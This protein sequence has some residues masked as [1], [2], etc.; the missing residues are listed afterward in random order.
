MTGVVA[1]RYTLDPSLRPHIRH[2][3]GLGEQ[4]RYYAMGRYGRMFSGHVSSVLSGHE[5]TG[6]ARGHFHACFLPTDEDADGLIDHLT[7]YARDG[8]EPRDL[9]ALHSLTFLSWGSDAIRL[10]LIGMYTRP[11]SEA[12]PSF[13]P[14]TRWRSVTPMVLFRHPKKYRRGDPKLNE[15]GRQIDGPEDQLYREWGY[16]QALEP[17]LSQLQRVNRLLGLQLQD[18]WLGWLRFDRPRRGERKRITNLAFGFDIAF[19]E[20]VTGPIAIGYGA[21][22]GLGQFIP[23]L[24]GKA[25][26]GGDAARTHSTVRTDS[27]P[28]NTR[29]NSLQS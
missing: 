21:H 5:G 14:A 12:I 20:P 8:F 2:T 19:A 4:A 17:N 18:E 25:K 15:E 29:P 27:A 7:V 1:I 6:P 26:V 23:V 10:E 22:F 28:A 11:E 9:K 13:T 3:L 16:L 24:P